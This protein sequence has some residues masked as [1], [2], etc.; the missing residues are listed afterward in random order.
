M[1]LGLSMAKKKEAPIKL[2]VAQKEQILRDALFIRCQSKEELHRWIRIYLGLDMPNYIVCDD[3]TRNPPSNSCP[4]DLIWEIYSKALDGTDKRF[5]QVLAFAARDSFKTLSAAV[6]ETLCLFHLDRDVGHLAALEEQAR[7]CQK[8]V[9]IFLK[10]PILRE[11]LTSKNKRSIEIAYYRSKEGVIS[12]V[13]F[14]KL[15]QED[16]DKYQ[17]HT[18]KIN[19]VIATVEA[20]NGLHPNFTTADELDLSDPGAIEEAKMM[21]TPKNGNLPIMFFTSTRKYSFGLVQKEIDNAHKTNMQVRHWNLIDVTEACTPDRHLPEEPQ[22]DIY[23]SEPDLK[24]ISAADWSLLSEQ[25]KEKFEVKKGYAGCLSNCTLFSQCKGRLVDKQKS[26]SKL[27]KKIDHVESLF[28]KVST[29]V[30]RAQL[31]CWKPSSEGLIYPRLSKD[32]HLLSAAEM[33]SKITGDQ[34]HPNFTKAQLID[35]MKS[36]GAAFYSGMDHGYSHNFSVTTA[37]LLGHVLYVIDV[38]SIRELELT[39]KIILCK[40]KIKHFNPIIYPDNA[41]PS[42]NRTFQ[43]NG[44]R[45]VNFDKDVKAGID[46]V[47]ARLYPGSNRPP[48]IFFLKGDPGVELLVSR[49]LQYHWKL[50][51]AG[52]LTDEPDKKDSDE[53]D[54]CRYLCQNVPISKAKAYIPA[55][56][57]KESKPIYTEDPNKNWLKNKI[58]ELTDDT[59]GEEVVVNGKNGFFWSF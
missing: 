37:A 8:Y 47:R 6:L 51:A 59:T 10:R 52:T 19:I 11:F 44:F 36:L 23:Y 33:A 35:L 38:I 16:K 25:E 2:D 7:N 9:E 29:E 1:I 45:V 50:D 21:G 27:L 49:L 46:A 14:D 42:D 30:A 40:A 39:D 5:T 12:P 58:K 55:N 31:L 22:I 54:S 13:Q 34:Y 32:V 3:D 56:A 41:Y 26:K 24:A 17:A 43:R 28:Q 18:Q 48:A 20:C 4:M 53:A 15:S 57:P